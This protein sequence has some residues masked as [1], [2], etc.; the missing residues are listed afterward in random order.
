MALVPDKHDQ[1]KAKIS[2]RVQ[3]RCLEEIDTILNKDNKDNFKKSCFGHLMGMKPLQ[4]QGQ[5]MLQLLFRQDSSCSTDRVIFHINNKEAEFGPKEFA[6]ITGLHFGVTP[7]FPKE[8]NL[9]RDVFKGKKGLVLLDIEKAFE[10][11]GR[12]KKGKGTTVLKLALLYVLYGILLVR[13][14]KSRRI[15]IRYIHLV[16]K[17]EA[18]NSFPWGR[19]VFEHLVEETRRCMK[20]QLK[21]YQ[22][23]K[24]IDPDFNENMKFDYDG[25]THALQVW[26]YEIMPD[27]ADLCATRLDQTKV[28]RMLQWKAEKIVTSEELK[29][30]AF[31]NLKPGDR[32]ANN[33]SY[34]VKVYHILIVC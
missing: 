4:F 5:L 13:D 21:E 30:L 8:S 27:V 1:F 10:E 12:K 34:H 19:V 25:F 31:F 14:R 24:A 15:D 18:F 7:S 26:A 20:K 28:P 33:V 2:C 23:K 22:K 6:L 29:R 11:V 3:W 9:H 16:D 17:L 32:T